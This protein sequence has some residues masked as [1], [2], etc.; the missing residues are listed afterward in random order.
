MKRRRLAAHTMKWKSLRRAPS[1]SEQ[2]VARS[3]LCFWRDTWSGHMLQLQPALVIFKRSSPSP[4]RC[5]SHL[6]TAVMQWACFWVFV[7]NLSLLLMNL[8]TFWE[9]SNFLS[10][11]SESVVF[12]AFL[13]TMVWFFKKS[14]M[15]VFR[16]LHGFGGHLQPLKPYLND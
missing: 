15:M 9:K 7:K 11:F 16:K 6:A 13:S 3:S 10:P 1:S 8:R 2:G 5:S 4:R 12:V 14:N